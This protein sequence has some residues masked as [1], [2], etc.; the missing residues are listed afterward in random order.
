M[1][2]LLFKCH[3]QRLSVSTLLEILLCRESPEGGGI[4]VYPFQPFLRFYI[5]VP[6]SYILTLHRVSTLLEILQ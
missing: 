4:Y 1:E 3:N 5:A 6:D 2:K